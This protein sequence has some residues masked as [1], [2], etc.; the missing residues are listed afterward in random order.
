[1]PNLG[2]TTRET[3]EELPKL[4]LIESP[5]NPLMRVVDI[6]YS[7]PFIFFVIMLVVFFGR[8]FVLMFIAVGA[9]VGFAI[10]GIIVFH[11]SSSAFRPPKWRRGL[12]AARGGS[13]N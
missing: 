5:S 11:L 1:M 7:L 12:R 13:R 4:V 9:V 10:D 8:N 6:L 2:Y 3:M